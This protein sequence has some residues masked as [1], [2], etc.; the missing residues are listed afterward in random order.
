MESANDLKEVCNLLVYPP[1]LRTS[2]IL[3][4]GI[5]SLISA[6]FTYFPPPPLHL[7]IFHFSS[8]T[9]LYYI[10]LPPRLSL[11]L[12]LILPYISYSLFE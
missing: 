8:F 11:D 2:H 9:S 12:N 7:Q 6:Y 3:A 4:S 10:H 1:T 5:F